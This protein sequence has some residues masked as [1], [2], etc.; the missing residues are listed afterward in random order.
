MAMGAAFSLAACGGES[1]GSG[2]DSGSRC[3]EGDERPAGDG[4]NTC[5]CIDGSWACTAIGCPETCTLGDRRAQGCET[6]ICAD[7]GSGPEWLCNS[8]G[9]CEPGSTRSTDDG[10]NTCTCSADRQWECTERDCAPCEFIGETRDAGD[11]CNTCTCQTYGWAC[12]LR[13]CSDIDCENGSANCDGDAQ[14]GC[15][16]D[17]R[18]ETMNCG[19]CGLYC[20]I[21]GAYAGCVDGECVIDHCQ[22]GYA[23]CNGD[24]SDGC[25]APVSGGGCENRCTPRSDAPS[26]GPATGSCECPEGTACVRGSSMNPGGE[27]CFPLTESCGGYG[28]CGCLGSCV[29]PD[30][31]GAFCTE[32]MS[33][34]GMIVNCDGI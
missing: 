27:Y 10:C 24:P 30:D 2:G 34:G 28:S 31:P 7:T 12:T 8:D 29:C 11:G 22:S 5:G 4:C 23:D 6:C 15:E 26:A 21:S 17:I 3:T 25:E 9:C 1:S 18:S 14:N 13:D 16:T 32:E 19:Q 33:L 20:A